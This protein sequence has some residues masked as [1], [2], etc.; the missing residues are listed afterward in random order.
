MQRQLTSRIGELLMD[1]NDAPP[2]EPHG[3]VGPANWYPE[4]GPLYPMDQLQG[5]GTP[6]PVPPPGLSAPPELPHGFI[7][8]SGAAGMMMVP[9]INKKTGETFTAGSTGFT[10]PDPNWV[11]NFQLGTLDQLQTGGGQR[12][13]PVGRPPYAPVLP[14]EIEALRPPPSSGPPVIMDRPPPEMQPYLDA[15]EEYLANNPGGMQPTVPLSP[16]HLGF[17]SDAT[18]S[19]P[20]QEPMGTPLPLPPTIQPGDLSAPPVAPPFPISFPNEPMGT[21]VS[22]SELSMP[23]LQSTIPQ[24][25]EIRQEPMG[26]MSAMAPA[27][28]EQNARLPL[29][30]TGQSPLSGADDLLTPSP[31]G[32]D[33][34][35]APLLALLRSQAQNPIFQNRQN[36]T[37]PLIGFYKDGGVVV[38]GQSVPES[39]NTGHHR[40]ELAYLTPAEQN[41]LAQVDMYGSSPPH[42]GPAGIP[43]FNGG[44][45]GGGGG[46][47]DGD[48]DGGGD[49]TGVGSGGTGVGSGSGGST[50]IGG[51][52]SASA[53][54]EA[55][56]DDPGDPG[57]GMEGEET[58]VDAQAEAAAAA[59]ANAAAANA[60]AAEAADID[61][62]AVAAAQAQAQQAQA[63]A[64]AQADIAAANAM[65]N[66]A[67]A[68]AMANHQ[69]Q[70]DAI[71]QAVANPPEPTALATDVIANLQ[72][73]LDA[74]DVNAMTNPEI[75]Q[76]GHPMAAA[77]FS[78]PSS[79]DSS[80]GLEG[81]ETA[82]DPVAEA[83]AV[84]AVAIAEA[85]AMEDQVSVT[86][87][88]SITLSDGTTVT[89]TPSEIAAMQSITDNASNVANQPNSDLTSLQVTNGQAVQAAVTNND[90]TVAQAAA[91]MGQNISGGGQGSQ[92]PSVGL[93]VNSE[94]GLTSINDVI[95]ALAMNRGSVNPTVGYAINDP[96]GLSQGSVRA[97]LIA[98][99]LN[100][101]LTNAM[102]GLTGLIG[103]AGAALGTVAGALEGRGMAPALGLTEPGR[104]SIA[105][106]VTDFFGE[107]EDP[108]I[109]GEDP[110]EIGGP[111]EE[112]LTA[113]LTPPTTTLPDQTTT[114][115]EEDTADAALPRI[116]SPAL[117]PPVAPPTQSFSPVNL[118]P[119]FSE[120]DAR[121]LLQQTGQLPFAG[122][123]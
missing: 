13:P 114:E 75:A 85:L 76:A 63:H 82:V 97:S 58:A 55:D 93:G 116:P 111:S 1:M 10:N 31:S 83:E 88:A 119:V 4:P 30:Q 26:Q 48:G 45:G 105:E 19:A 43:N 27:F 18:Y 9:W 7:G 16:A 84:E 28:T 17:L 120:Q 91:V 112:E 44:G 115:E 65:A 15:R 98:G 39:Y 54:D 117:P 12:P 78:M 61:A 41:L 100:P 59:A 110:G 102:F 53:G 42:P 72:A 56:V 96:T 71:A 74:I 104:G 89:G 68:Q 70:L 22:L 8:P 99:R 46:D 87:T 66:P 33:D 34:F 67:I 29:Q 57:F 49:D 2:K 109:G 6:A 23:M 107:S 5:K 11:Q 86:S 62:A 36:E 69:A 122:I 50:G 77:G 121:L 25:T 90:I 113:L 40:V 92:S 101:S 37:P 38:N 73:Q 14:P 81:E 94:V 106:T 60:A 3:F 35:L 103:P 32:A 20:T 47:G 64:Q 51:A 79:S 52:E 95:E 108:A 123:V 118:P 21:P 80:L 24:Q